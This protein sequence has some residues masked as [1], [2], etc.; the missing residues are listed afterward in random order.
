MIMGTLINAIA[1]SNAAVVRGEMCLVMKLMSF[2]CAM[3]MGTL[4]WVQVCTEWYYM[5]STVQLCHPR[6]VGL[7][8]VLIS[9][10]VPE[11]HLNA[12]G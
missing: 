12:S 11:F 7:G 6:E 1:Y 4:K 10:E 3:V 8:A 9:L 2:T 5:G